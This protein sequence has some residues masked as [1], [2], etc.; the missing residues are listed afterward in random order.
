M[1]A[2]KGR[3]PKDGFCRAV[4]AAKVRGPKYTLRGSLYNL[5]AGNVVNRGHP[6]LL[7]NAKDKK[8]FDFVYFRWE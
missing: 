3:W 2:L 7:F 8:N 5:K 4:S 6:G 1:L